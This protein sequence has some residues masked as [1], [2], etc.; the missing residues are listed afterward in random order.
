MI[1]WKKSA[2]LNK[3]TV[4][5]LKLYL[6]KYPKSG[7]K[8]IRI[9]EGIDCNDELIVSFFQCH[10]LCKSCAAKK[11]YVENPEVQKERHGTLEARKSHSVGSKKA[12]IDDPTKAERQGKSLSNTLK[13]N[14]NISKHVGELHKK[15]YE[16]N[17]MLAIEHS[18][19]MKQLYEDPE[20]RKKQS[21]AQKKSYQEN[22]ERTQRI[23]EGLK[24]AYQNDPMIAQKQSEVMKKRFTDGDPIEMHHLIYD[25]NNKDKFTIPLRS[26]AHKKVHVAFRRSGFVIPHI[27]RKEVT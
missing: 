27:K 5:E 8:V 16:D 24:M 17:P 6:D 3:C 13:S 9:C 11:Y 15:R 20:V 23:S 2:K 19:T 12:Y 10:D 18:K 1:D 4:D 7:K 25:E 21:L 14:P 26:S 22:P